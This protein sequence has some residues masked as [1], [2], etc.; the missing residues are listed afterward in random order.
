[1]GTGADLNITSG[2]TH[3]T[4]LDHDHTNA[5][6]TTE[7]VTHSHTIDH[8]HG[9]FSSSGQSV[10]HSHTINHDHASFTSGGSGTLTTSAIGNHVHQSA[11][12]GTGS[13]AANIRG[14]AAASGE[15]PSGFGYGA[16]GHDHTIAGHTHSIDVPNFGGSSGDN[17]VDHSHSIDVPAFGGSSGGASVGHTHDVNLPTFTGI[18]SSNGAHVHATGEITGRIG[19]VTGVSGNSV[20]VSG[21]TNPPFLALNYIIKT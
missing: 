6:S 19:L 16:G 20:M 21:A 8:D 4:A 15:I 2:G 12:F 7:S 1:M 9:A 13:T 5:T 11:V 10:S 14:G 18:S 17:S 3:Q